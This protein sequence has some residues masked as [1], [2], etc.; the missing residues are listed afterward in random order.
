MNEFYFSESLH[1]QCIVILYRHDIRI[2]RLEIA[3]K[4]APSIVICTIYKILTKDA[5]NSSLLTLYAE[6]L[7]KFLRR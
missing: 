4:F 3:V 6:K 2:Q 1:S 7:E 5:I